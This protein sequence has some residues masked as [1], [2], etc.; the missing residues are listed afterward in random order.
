MDENKRGKDDKPS[1]SGER[2]GGQD[3]TWQGGRQGIFVHLGSVFE[4]IAK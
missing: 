2:G 1:G 4:D 3:G